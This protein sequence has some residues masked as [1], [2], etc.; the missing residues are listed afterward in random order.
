MSIAVM[1]SYTIVAPDTMT[2][3]VITIVALD[4]ITCDYIIISHGMEAF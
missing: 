3:D 2:C 4:I 1:L